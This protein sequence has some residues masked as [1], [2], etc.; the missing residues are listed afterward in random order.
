MKNTTS[1]TQSLNTC[2]AY[3]M[4]LRHLAVLVAAAALGACASSS[5][6]TEPVVY[7]QSEAAD[8]VRMRAGQTIRV[9][10]IRVRFTGVESDSRCPMDAI[11]IWAGDAVAVFLIELDCECRA[12]AF[13]LRLH[14][15]LQPRN[16]TAY[17]RRLELLLLAPY[18]VAPS[19]IK[20]DAYSAWVRL[21]RVE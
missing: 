8:S 10:G 1:L 3:P 4:Q 21:T 9:D 17:G 20:P 15:T 11:C 14:T 6:P 16:G 13:Q 7:S 12:A 18:P 5:A 2:L 19:P